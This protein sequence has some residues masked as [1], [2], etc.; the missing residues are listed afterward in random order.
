MTRD[1]LK[2]RVLQFMQADA[3]GESFEALAM[4][5]HRWQRSHAPVI[6]ALCTGPVREWTDIPSV[7]VGL[8]KSLPVG[9]V[10]EGEAAVSF[11]TS[12]TTGGGQGVHRLRDTDLYDTG[13]IRHFHR[14]VPDAPHAVVAL[15]EDP[16]LNPHSSLSHMVASFASEAVWTFRDGLQREV[17]NGAIRGASGPV[18]VPSTAFALAEWLQGPVEPLPSGS[19]LMVTGGF[20]GRTHAFTDTELYAR[21]ESCLTPTR[22]VTEYGMTELSSQL[23]GRPGQPYT[24]PRWMRV[25]AVDPGTGTP[26]PSGT[27]GQLRFI[28]LANL[29]STV[30]I[31]T[32]DCG[33]IDPDGRVHLKGRL[34][35]APARGCSLTVEEAWG[36][37]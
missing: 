16:R 25:L 21:A 22:T 28:D 23:W 29:D 10:R 30:A 9:T 5:L 33:W 26:L 3:A 14:C 2:A 36:Q 27:S 6:E 7:P 20:K 32:L 4:D 1:A 12:G 31:D 19:V 34:E 13:A 8:F 17:L 24:P 37:P 15:L 18:F 11:R 35:G